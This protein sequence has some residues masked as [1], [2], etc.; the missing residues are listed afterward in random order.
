ML[1]M[2]NENTKSEV[3]VRAEL[4]AED[5]ATMQIL[6]T[7]SFDDTTFPPYPTAVQQRIPTP[8]YGP[9]TGTEHNWATAERVLYEIPDNNDASTYDQQNFPRHYDGFNNDNISYQHPS[10]FAFDADTFR[11]FTPIQQVEHNWNNYIDFRQP[12]LELQPTF[13][14]QVYDQ[15][16][17][18]YYQ[19]VYEGP[20][21]DLVHEIYE[22]Y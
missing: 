6:H 5:D 16:E 9:N 2:K 8:N 11:P 3:P 21:E 14:L 4:L 12:M 18:V 17:G 1:E 22:D 10:T 7:E 20:D 13:Q 15:P 19:G